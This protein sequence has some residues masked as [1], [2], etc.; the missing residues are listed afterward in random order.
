MTVFARKFSDIFLGS[1]SKISDE[2]PVSG[3]GRG[4]VLYPNKI[5]Q[6][7][8]IDDILVLDVFRQM[9]FRHTGQVMWLIWKVQFEFFFWFSPPVAMVFA[10]VDHRWP[11]MEL[12][13]FCFLIFH[14]GGQ[15]LDIHGHW[16]VRWNWL[17]VGEMQWSLNTGPS[18]SK[19]SFSSVCKVTQPTT[20]N[21]HCLPLRL[22]EINARFWSFSSFLLLKFCFQS[23]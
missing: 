22:D 5:K 20:Y 3:Y 10:L 1:T 6:T 21:L 19:T 17:A 14:N 12:R 13:R 8:V 23:G 11:C 18:T 4:V 15:V 16:C 2:I 9:V 7:G